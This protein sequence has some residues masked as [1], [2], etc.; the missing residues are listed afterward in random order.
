MSGNSY[1]LRGL[2]FIASS[3]YMGSVVKTNPTINI[4]KKSGKV[5]KKSEKLPS[6]PVPRPSFSITKIINP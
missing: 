5:D 6:R 4:N 3:T 1:L 2:I